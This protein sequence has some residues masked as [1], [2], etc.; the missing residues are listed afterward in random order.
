MRFAECPYCG[1]AYDVSQY[2]AG[3][4]LRCALCKAFLRVPYKYSPRL[5]KKGRI[6]HT[7]KIVLCGALFAGILA[8]VIFWQAVSP[9][10][11][12]E[13]PEVSPKPGIPPKFSNITELLGSLGTVKEKIRALT[14]RLYKDFGVHFN[15][16]YVEPF[17]LALQR[18]QGYSFSDIFE[19]YVCILEALYRKFRDQFEMPLDIPPVQ[20]PLLVV[21]LNS[22][23]SF[24]EYFKQTGQTIPPD[25]DGIYLANKR[26]CIIY[27][28]ITPTYGRLLHEA[29][30]QLIHY[31]KRYAKRLKTPFWF[32]EGIAEYM[33]VLKRDEFGRWRVVS[34][35]NLERLSDLRHGLVGGLR[36]DL[37]KLLK[38]TV[39][40]FWGWFES[41][42][43]R[44][45]RIRTSRK[46]NFYY[47]QAWALVYFL[48]H[49][50]STHFK[51]YFKLELQGKG[52]YEPFIRIFGDLNKLQK[53]FEG[54]I[55]GLK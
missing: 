45:D 20:E 1:K 42:I 44:V 17:L 51:E 55:Q 30:H 33:S 37:V 6:Y 38:L 2:E 12:V 25:L 7:L 4:L 19:D 53:E 46:A 34:D 15:I 16:K 27:Q 49:G 52:G 13:A 5:N 10:E 14:H 41:P 35:L 18:C 39:E 50:R 36:I 29:V 11:K 26:F 8:G 23:K 40:E 54:F 24:D 48:L 32:H 3:T 22:R 43:S 28:G 47:A 21:V 31:H 9:R